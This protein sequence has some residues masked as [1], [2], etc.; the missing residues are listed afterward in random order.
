M[1][2]AIFPPGQGSFS[3]LPHAYTPHNLLGKRGQVADQSAP[4]FTQAE[5]AVVIIGA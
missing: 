3:R 5:G 2:V 1:N 4:H